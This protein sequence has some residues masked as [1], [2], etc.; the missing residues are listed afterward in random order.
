MTLETTFD[1]G[2]RCLTRHWPAADPWCRLVLV[3]GLGEHSGRYN[4]VGEHL[5]AA[6]IDAWSFDL[7]GFGESGGRRAYVDDFGRYLDDV[8]Q[9]LDASGSG[10]RVLLG[11]SLGG[12]I[13]LSYVLS[14]RPAPDILAL[15]AP[16]LNADVPRW[17]RLLAPLLGRVLPKLGI[18]NAIRGEQLSSDPAV[19]EAYFADSLVVTK[20]TARL[21]A[22]IFAAMKRTRARVHELAIPTLVIHGSDDTL[23]PARF[24]EPLATLPNVTRILFEGFRHESFNEVEGERALETMEEWLQDQ[25]VALA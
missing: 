3:H 16:A 25:V 22:E 11:H 14:D 1:D 7:R 9:R 5:S 24:S 10:P 20:T 6:G 18:P 19:G 13:A 4:H 12:L 2:T 15:S 23:V 17:Q 21:G 8:A